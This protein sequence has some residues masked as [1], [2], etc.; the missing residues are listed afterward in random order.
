M[1][2]HSAIDVSSV[3]WPARS[4]NGPPPTMSSIGS[5]ELGALNSSVVP[6]ASPAASP[7]RQPRK[8]SLALT[9]PTD[10]PAVLR[11]RLVPAGLGPPPHEHPLGAGLGRLG[12]EPALLHVL[13]PLGDLIEGPLAA[14]PVADQP[15]I[16]S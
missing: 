4:P 16:S 6:S 7:T 13:P 8:R 5:N 15:A 12:V 1:A 9:S 11:C 2:R 10:V 14:E 3:H